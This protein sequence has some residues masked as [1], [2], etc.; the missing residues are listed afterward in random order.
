MFLTCD[1]PARRRL[2]NSFDKACRR[3]LFLE[4]LEQRRLLAT[5]TVMG[6]ADNDAISAYVQGDQLTV[7]VNGATF[8]VPNSSID[9]I[10]VLGLAGN[11]TI[12]IDLGVSQT[13]EL[14]G[15]DG[16]DRI[17]A[18]KGPSKIYG[19]AGSDVLQG[20]P[21]SDI[22]FG[23]AGDD[24]LG[25]GDGDDYLIGGSGNDKLAGEAGNDWLF[26]DATNSLPANVVD[27]VQYALAYADVNY[28]SDGLSGGAGDDILLAGNGNDRASGDDGND[29]VVGGVGD[30]GL[31]GGTG[32]DLI[33]GDTLFRLKTADVD[34]IDAVRRVQAAAE[35]L[36]AADA[37]LAAV[38][39]AVI[40]T[41]NDVIDAGD[42]NDAV[43][44]QWGNDQILAGLGADFANGG[45]GN[46]SIAGGGDNDALYG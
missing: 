39:P 35:P 19:G 2:G 23:G 28:G 31:A 45:D 10:R 25:G 33:L 8:S 36:L 26:G 38:D 46:D 43:L 21:S 37:S 29:V 14:D 32:N 27:P 12:K 30:D 7:N 1:R 13:T 16:N 6:T 40:R 4:D 22:I 34:A 20:G 5:L 24:S 9:N 41:F 15:G 18:G 3:R 42:G 17:A 44:G 11:D